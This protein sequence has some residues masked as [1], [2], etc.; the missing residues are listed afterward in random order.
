MHGTLRV[1]PEKLHSAITSAEDTFF[2][3]KLKHLQR[4]SV[5]SSQNV[6]HSCLFP[7]IFSYD[8]NTDSTSEN[9]Q[10]V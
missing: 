10:L 8:F 9:S 6:S 3:V 1:K 4:T 5:T 2:P 7:D